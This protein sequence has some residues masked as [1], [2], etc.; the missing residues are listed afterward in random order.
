MQDQRHL[1][2]AVTRSSLTPRQPRTV[3]SKID[4]NRVASQTVLLQFSQCLT[5]LSIHHRHLVMILGPRFAD[6]GQVR[7]EARTRTS[8]GL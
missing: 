5:D 1:Q 4:D 3:V 8:P 2:P 6:L 7:M